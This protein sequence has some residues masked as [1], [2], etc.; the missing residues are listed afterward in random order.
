MNSLHDKYSTKPI[1]KFITFLWSH[2]WRNFF[3]KK[4][5]IILIQ[6]DSYETEN[7][8][9]PVIKKHKKA[10]KKL[11]FQLCLRKWESL[12]KSRTEQSPGGKY[13]K[14]KTR[15]RKHQGNVKFCDLWHIVIESL[16]ISFWVLDQ[17]ILCVALWKDTGE[18]WNCV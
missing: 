2:F 4:V 17:Q 13:M 15:K 6:K 1:R 10:Y 7:I 8:A 18:T 11:F 16:E 9:L 3:F 5:K 14:I 12:D